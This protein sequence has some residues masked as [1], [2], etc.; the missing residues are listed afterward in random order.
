MNQPVELPVLRGERVVLRPLCR[1]DTPTVR[2]MLAEPEVARWWGEYD[3]AR[4]E[5]DFFDALC[6]SAYAIEVDGEW[7]GVIMFEE[8]KDPDYKSA[9]IDI[10]LSTAIQGGGFGTDALHTLIRYLINVRGH[11]RVTIDP[12]A[13]NARAIHVYEKVGFKPVGIMRAY[14]RRGD[15]QW[16]DGLLMDLLAG[17]FGDR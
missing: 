16:H 3:D 2:A 12:A 11:H 8:V 1:D 5:R 14:E 6:V 15:G 13:D 17:E 4:L 9:S 10:T 7:A